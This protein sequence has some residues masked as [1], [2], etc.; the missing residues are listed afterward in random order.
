M[1][2]I[3]GSNNNDVIVGTSGSDTIN[4][5]NGDDTVNG[6]A[7]S[8]SIN[9]GAGND[10][11]DGGSGSDQLNG[12]SGDDTLIYNV[13][14]NAAA[15]TKDVYTGGAGIDTVVLQLSSAQWLD[16]SVRAE[17]QRYVELLATVKTNPQG[18]VSNGSASDFMFTFGSSTL[19]VQMME[20]LV[21]AVQQTAEGPY[22]AVNYL[23]ALISGSD[24]GSAVEAGGTN[25][26]NIGTPTVSG[27]L[28][29]DDLDGADDVFQAVAAGAS[30]N[31]GTYSVGTNGVWTYALNNS[32]ES[33]QALAVGE[34][35]S[36]SFTV[37]SADGT[38]KLVKIS[39]VGSNDAP[40]VSAALTT[41]AAEGNGSYSRNLLAGSSDAD[42]GETATLSV[43]DVR[44]SVNGAA[45]SNGPPAGVS[46][47]GNTLT[48]DPTSAAFNHLAAGQHATI[49]VAYNIKDVH[50]ATV[51]QTETIT[52][53]GT[54]DVPVV[55]GSLTARVSEDGPQVTLDA[56]ANASD[57]DDGTTLSVVGL[58]A[59]LPAGVSYSA[60]MHS[61]VTNP[62]NAAFQGLAAGQSATV[63][64]DYGVSDGLSTT[65]TSASFT[66]TG[67]NDVVSITSGAQSGSV[68][69]DAAPQQASGVI[70]FNDADLIDVHAASFVPHAGA[71]GV[72]T[73]A[74]V[75][76][77]ASTENGQVG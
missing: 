61:F 48:I 6:G 52:I 50:G 15:G 73:L 21:V 29:A 25:N 12:G 18:E 70:S 33:V 42:H 5:G 51:A 63:N 34:S 75:S 74:P 9:G 39:I 14:E 56:L 24:A 59:T 77:S 55:S 37:R 31:Y 1:G 62:G 49:V 41:G 47:V 22:N 45:A 2:T 46:L 69:E 35:L 54:N 66:I 40:V 3:T 20:K 60:A 72:F 44:F 8:D 30:A 67:T 53:N 28:Y 76:E 71:L 68:I 19:T 17:L 7:G 26:A 13:L 57:V 65:A 64:V 10:I 38:S 32:H 36:D 27:D 43:A 58:P 23:A 16:K 4:S 11:L